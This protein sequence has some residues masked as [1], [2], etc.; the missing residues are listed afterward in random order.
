MSM[1]LCEDAFNLTDVC[2]VGTYA[3]K[4]QEAAISMNMTN[5]QKG[6]GI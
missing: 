3:V 1:V 2:K 4:V 5:I 6:N